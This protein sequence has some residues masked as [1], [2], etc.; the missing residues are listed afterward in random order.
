MTDRSK[1]GGNAA[2]LHHKIVEPVARAESP[3]RERPV[4][5]RSSEEL[6]A[7][8]FGQVIGRYTLLR[9]IAG[10]GMAEVYVARAYAAAGVEKRVAI[11][12][13]LPQHSHN[14]RFVEMLVDEA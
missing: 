6:R 4:S 5:D 9:R 11:K 13:M 10:G 8:G 3:C 14:E 1:W 12:K 2:S 7:L